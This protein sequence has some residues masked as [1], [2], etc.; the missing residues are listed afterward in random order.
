M[1]ALRSVMTNLHREGL[2]HLYFMFKEKRIKDILIFKEYM[3]VQWKEMHYFQLNIKN[4]I[5]SLNSLFHWELFCTL[6]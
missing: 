2:R 6:I 1:F 3:K 5:S 4:S